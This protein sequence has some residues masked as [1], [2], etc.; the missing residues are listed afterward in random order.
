MHAAMICM[1]L[2]LN[3]IK[4]AK[5]EITASSSVSSV[6]KGDTVILE[7]ISPPVW[8]QIVIAI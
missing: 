3:I 1:C 4:V 2:F 8:L 5:L 7:T 6:A